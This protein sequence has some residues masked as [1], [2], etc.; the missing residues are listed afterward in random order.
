MLLILITAKQPSKSLSNYT[1][2]LFH[3]S[4]TQYTLSLGISCLICIWHTQPVLSYGMIRSRMMPRDSPRNAWMMP[5]D[6]T[7]NA[8]MM[9]RDSPRNARMMPRDFTHNAL[10]IIGSN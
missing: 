1:V 9:P 2:K 3:L 4:S 7:R 8:R 10:V 5:H 6:S